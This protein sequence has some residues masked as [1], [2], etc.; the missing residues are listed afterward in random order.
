MGEK[1]FGCVA[2]DKKTVERV[3][4]ERC[5]VS[6]CGV[7]QMRMRIKDGYGRIIEVASCTLIGKKSMKICD[8][9]AQYIWTKSKVTFSS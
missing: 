5:I 2:V 3:S 7:R 1:L 6:C 4:A 9:I 8:S